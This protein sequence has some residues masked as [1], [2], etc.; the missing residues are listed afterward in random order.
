MHEK[1]GR[2]CIA[3]AAL[4]VVVVVPPASASP[5]LTE[6]SVALAQGA[7]VTA[8]NTGEA[9]FTTGNGFTLSCAQAHWTGTVTSNTGNQISV[10]VPVG[11]FTF[12]GTAGICTTSQ[13]NIKWSIKSKLCLQSVAKTDN[14]SITGCGGPVLLTVGGCEFSSPTLLGTF[15]TGTDASLSLTKQQFVQIGG[16]VYA[17]I[18]PCG[19]GGYLDLYFDLSTSNEAT[20]LIS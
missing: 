6:S 11:S 13:G 14:V 19:G 2:A 10:E 1:L 5:V 4:A 17:G 18:V 16:S 15:M 9:L 3:I 20:L 8:R 12:S 7:S